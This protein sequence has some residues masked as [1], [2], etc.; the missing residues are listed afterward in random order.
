MNAQA[1]VRPGMAV[2]E[3]DIFHLLVRM[4]STDVLSQFACTINDVLA[5]SY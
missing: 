4:N 2:M 1:G 5:V 3:K